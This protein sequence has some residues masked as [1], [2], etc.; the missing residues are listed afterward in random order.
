MKSKKMLSIMM[1]LILTCSNL[2]EINAALVTNTN[3][4]YV[5]M[6][7]NNCDTQELDNNN[8]WSSW[9]GGNEGWYEGAQGKLS[10]QTST[11]W[12]AQM[13][14][15]GYGGCWGA[16]V[17]SNNYRLNKGQ[18]Y[19]I[20]FDIKSES[21]DKWIQLAIGTSEN[22]AY[23]DWIKL[24]KG[25]VYNYR[26]NFIAQN[27]A[28][29]MYFGIGGEFGNRIEEDYSSLTEIPDDID[30]TN[31]TIIHCNNINIQS[32]ESV[33]TKE[34]TSK[35]NNGYNTAEVII[36]PIL[37]YDYVSGFYDGKYAKVY[38]YH[39]LQRSVGVIDITGKEIIPVK[40]SFVL[41]GKN[42]ILTK[43]SDD[44]CNKFDLD[45]NL[46]Y[47][48]G[49][50]TLHVDWDDIYLPDDGYVYLEIN[51]EQIR[52][53]YD[54]S[55]GIQTFPK[56]FDNEK[57]T[58]VKQLYKNYLVEKQEQND[59]HYCIYDKNG[60]ELLDLGTD[61]IGYSVDSNGK[62]IY[63]TQKISENLQ[64]PNAND[65]LLNSDEVNTPI[66]HPNVPKYQTVLVNYNGKI[67]ASIN[68][69]EY[70]DYYVLNDILILKDTNNLFSI[71]DIDGNIIQSLDEYDYICF[72]DNYIFL[73]DINSDW[74]MFS[75]T[76]KFI[77]TIG[78]YLSICYDEHGD[79]FAVEDTKEQWH[80]INNKNSSEI[81]MSN[82]D[83]VYTI[84]NYLIGKEHQDYG[85]SY[86]FY[87]NGQKVL[88]KIKDYSYYDSFIWVIDSNNNLQFYDNNFY[89]F[90]EL[91]NIEEIGA[92][93]QTYGY[94]SVKINNKWAVYKITL[95]KN[96]K[97]D[98]ETTTK[99]NDKNITTN[100]INVSTEN[101][102][103]PENNSS[104][105]DNNNIT[106]AT[107]NKKKSNILSVAK[108]KKIVNSKKKIKIYLCKVKNASGYSVTFATNKKLKKSKTIYTKKLN[109]I[110]AK[111]K[112]NIKYYFRVRGYKLINGKKTF[113]PWSSIKSIKVKK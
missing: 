44:I 11:S 106:I 85:S 24:Y 38:N 69:N 45:G 12:T 26:K 27:D 68:D 33:N 89:K 48:Y 9:F 94:T 53:N 4:N 87:M 49:V 66:C 62:L 108:I 74:F 102:T 75:Q 43:D 30:S 104:I 22:R 18:A 84:G 19:T 32:I 35:N 36:E 56:P 70:T 63:F 67:L 88:T 101:I 40:Y 61:Y 86:D 76:G 28:E 6:S 92:Y 64:S 58:N 105:I 113:G 10:A 17:Y 8:T 97:N 71:L 59:L 99:P 80:L 1:S 103:V 15:I 98:N 2:T 25:E 3:D 34:T 46:I 31:S 81:L 54:G 73:K 37:N 60:K 93:S 78:N 29:I 100:N 23:T 109:L 41:I 65:T 111:L 95:P 47:T 5:T 79:Y 14:S 72:S 13:D 112:G 91:N 82:Y 107:K 90:S 83:S 57:I 96:Q 39:N 52:L 21:C 110:I 77:K 20:S 16:Q 7:Q 55:E 42:F 51:G 50:D